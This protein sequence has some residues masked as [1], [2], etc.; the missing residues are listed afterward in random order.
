MFVF[1]SN[2]NDLSIRNTLY[3]K[4]DG[5]VLRAMPFDVPLQCKF[6]R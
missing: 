1:Q 5:P 2:V 4:P 6:P 3:Y